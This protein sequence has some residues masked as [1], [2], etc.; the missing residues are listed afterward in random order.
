MKKHLLIVLSVI[1][2]VGFKPNVS[3]QSGFNTVLEYCT[4]TWCQYCPCGHTVIDGF[5]HYFNS[6]L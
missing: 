2:L 6:F 4:G 3:A 5:L 1:A